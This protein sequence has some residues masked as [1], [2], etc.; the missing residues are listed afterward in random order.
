M[1][2]DLFKVDDRVRITLTGADDNECGPHL[3]M[4]GVIR[5]L[6]G[7]GYSV[8]RDDRGPSQIAVHYNDSCLEPERTSFQMQPDVTLDEIE[9][10]QEIIE[11]LS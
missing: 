8:E 10:Y 11:G 5:A 7:D 1:S 4:C 9:R 3:G 2:N 6:R